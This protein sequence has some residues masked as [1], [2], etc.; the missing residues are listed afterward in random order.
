MPSYK[1]SIK[2]LFS[3]MLLLALRRN[4]LLSMLLA[5]SI[6]I[7]IAVAFSLLPQIFAEET[8]SILTALGARSSAILLSESTSLAGSSRSCT[9][10]FV[11]GTL[12][13]AGNTSL[14]VNTFLVDSG[15]YYTLFGKQ[16]ECLDSCVFVGSAI[17]SFLNVTRGSSINLCVE[18]VCHSFRV[19]GVVSSGGFESSS[20]LLIYRTTPPLELFPSSAEKIYLCV[21]PAA[22]QL[23]VFTEDL[24][25]TLASLANLLTLTLF[26]LCP[27]VMYVSYARAFSSIQPELEVLYE[28]GVPR[29]VLRHVALATL[30]VLSVLMLIYGV[31]LGTLFT[32]LSL[33]ILRFFNIFIES[34]PLPAVEALAQLL[35][36]FTVLSLA[37]LSLAIR[38]W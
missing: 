36:V 1:C 19:S 14:R 7:A 15:S 23:Q 28:S 29:R 24:K 20:I 17:S 18:G 33:W 35:A 38:R 32:H 10:S 31:C 27:P 13:T 2:S 6:P 21:E 26:M 12:V 25:S 34:R 9:E 8:T 5:T 30:M 3:T 11:I 16:L 22:R 4:I 37:A